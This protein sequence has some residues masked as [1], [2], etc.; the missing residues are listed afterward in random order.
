MHRGQKVKDPVYSVLFPAT[1]GRR[2]TETTP[3]HDPELP[4]ARSLCRTTYLHRC[5]DQLVGKWLWTVARGSGAAPASQQALG[6]FRLHHRV[7]C[8]SVTHVGPTQLSMVRRKSNAATTNTFGTAI[9]NGMQG[10]LMEPARTDDTVSWW[11]V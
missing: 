10:P 11:R 1:W 6:N 4:A 5:R 7:S 3:G 9:E 2:T 8:A